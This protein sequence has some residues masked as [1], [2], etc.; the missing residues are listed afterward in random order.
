MSLNGCFDSNKIGFLG[1]GVILREPP[2]R[3]SQ[4]VGVK[5][6]HLSSSYLLVSRFGNDSWMW[7]VGIRI[8]RYPLVLVYS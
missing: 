7:F 2:E 3:E 8:S 1:A 5:G 4:P 6:T